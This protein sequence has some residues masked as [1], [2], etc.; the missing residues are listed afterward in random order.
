MEVGGQCVVFGGGDESLTEP[1]DILGGFSILG[2]LC[3]LKQFESLK[4]QHFSSLLSI[5][6]FFLCDDVSN[7]VMCHLSR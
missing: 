7:R 5:N 4:R 1:K 6:F 2:S 3:E